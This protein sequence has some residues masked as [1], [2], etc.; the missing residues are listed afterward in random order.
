MDFQ[1]ILAQDGGFFGGGK[2]GKGW[3]IVDPPTNSLLLG[4]VTSV[5]LLATIDQ[6]MRPW[7]CMRTNNRHTHRQRETEFI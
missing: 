7:Q 5:P 4:V 6:E 1:N 3:C 2:Y